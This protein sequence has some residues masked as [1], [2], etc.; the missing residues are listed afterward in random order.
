MRTMTMTIALLAGSTAA[1]PDILVSQITIANN[2][3]IVG[4]YQ[5]YSFA[6][7]TCNIGDAPFTYVDSTNQHPVFTSSIYRLQD[8]RFEQIGLGFVGH[9]FFPL[10]SN[11]C[12]IGCNPGSPGMLGDGCSNTIGAGL[13]GSQGGLGPRSEISAYSGDFP[14]PFTTINQSG[15]AIYK[16]VK[17]NTTDISDLSAMY[18]VETQYI[19]NEE[20]TDAARN[21]NASTRRLAFSPGANS[22]ILSGDTFV[23]QAA[24]YAWQAVDPGVMISEVQI[25]G[26]GI[27][28]VGS[29]ATDLGDGTWRYDYTIHNQNSERGIN[30][31]KVPIGFYRTA[32]D[33]MFHDVAYLD[34]V[35]NAIDGTDWSQ[36]LLNGYTSWSADAH[37]DDNPLANAIRWGTSY[38]FSFISPYSPITKAAELGLFDDDGLDAVVAQIVAP[39]SGPC[40]IDINGDLTVNYFDISL[41]ISTFGFEDLNADFTGDGELN[42]FDISQFLNE[43]AEGCP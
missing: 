6:D 37:F 28:H 36:T 27:V 43:Y 35:D 29:N 9:T 14:Y 26:D 19:S 15:N 20:Q 25:P 18:F 30:S 13:A 31:F 7:T 12:N 10:Q 34:E 39:Y 17:V 16:R 40:R 1:G 32:T 8:G 22:P 41:F 3:G 2:Y 5:A 33:L 21:N 23:G 42:F 11:A 4:D 38:S 24:I